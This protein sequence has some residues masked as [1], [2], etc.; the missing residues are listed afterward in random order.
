[1]VVVAAVEEVAGVLEGGPAQG[2]GTRGAGPLPRTEAVPQRNVPQGSL[3]LPLPPAVLRSSAWTKLSTATLL[4]SS[5]LWLSSAAA[6]E[7]Q[8]RQW[9]TQGRSLGLPKPLKA[10][11]L[12]PPPVM[13]LRG[14]TMTTSVQTPILRSQGR[15]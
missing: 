3:C 13:T 5:R 9:G 8:L 15:W 10:P 6:R 12:G 7:V 11:L 2:E 14:P 4:A 1:M